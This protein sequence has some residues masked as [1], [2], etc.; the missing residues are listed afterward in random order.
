MQER[1]KGFSGN[2]YVTAETLL[3]YLAPSSEE[4]N[5]EQA[6]NNVTYVGI[7]R[8]EQRLRVRDNQIARL[9]IYT[10]DTVNLLKLE[11]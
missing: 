11:K 8:L 10:S 6:R 5:I 3:K 1:V 9:K 4:A 2:A 7:R